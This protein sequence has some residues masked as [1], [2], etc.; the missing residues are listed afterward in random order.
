MK[1]GIAKM[2]PV[3]MTGLVAIPGGLAEMSVV[4]LALNADAA[5]VLAYPLFRLFSILLVMPPPL[6]RRFRR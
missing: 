4:A 5:F 2:G 3:L 6:R 1:E